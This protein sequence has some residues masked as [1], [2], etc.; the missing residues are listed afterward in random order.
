[1]AFQALLTQTFDL[2]LKKKFLIFC[3]S[4][5]VSLTRATSASRPPE[6]DL[7]NAGIRDASAVPNAPNY[8]STSST[9]T[10]KT[11]CTAAGTTPKP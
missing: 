11:N 5:P 6:P 2:V 7:T 1:M 10:K 8:W 4:V 3:F 9:F